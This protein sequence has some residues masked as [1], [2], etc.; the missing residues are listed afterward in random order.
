MKN[1]GISAVEVMII[2]AIIGIL[3]AICVPSIKRYSDPTI[4]LQDIKDK[5]AECANFKKKFD[6]VKPTVVSDNLALHIT[7][8]KAVGAW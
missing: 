2:V 1:S 6:E 7:A 8:C 4:E 3:A 5:Q